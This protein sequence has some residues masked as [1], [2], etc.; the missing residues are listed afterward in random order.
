MRARAI[1]LALLMLFGFAIAPGVTVVPVFADGPPEGMVGVPSDSIESDL[2]EQTPMGQVAQDLQTH[3]IYTS[4]HADTL[5]LL[6]T[7]P[8]QAKQFTDGSVFGAGPIAIVFSDLEHSE[9]REVAIPVV[10]VED[11][12]GYQPDAARGTYEDGSRWIESIEYDGSYAVFSIP[13]FSNQTVTFEGEV[14]ISALA[15]DGDT[16]TYEMLEP[17]AVDDVVLEVTGLDSTSSESASWSDLRDGDTVPIEIGG[18]VPVDLS[19]TLTGHGGLNETD[20]PSTL[21]DERGLWR[22]AASETYL[23]HGHPGSI[24]IYDYNFSEVTELSA[25]PWEHLEFSPDGKYLL[26]LNDDEY[27]IYETDGW[28]VVHSDSSDG[29]N[30]DFSYG[31]SD[32]QSATWHPEGE[33][34]GIADIGLGSLFVFEYEGSGSFTHYDT[35]N[36]G[37]YYRSIK[38][39]PDGEVIAAGGSDHI[40]FKDWKNGWSTIGSHSTYGE[41]LE[42]IAFHP[43]GEMAVGVTSH[44]AGHA[45]IYLEEFD[46][47]EVQTLPGTDEHLF[48][49]DWHP[50]GEYI[51][52]VSRSSGSRV[53]VWE[54][55]GWEEIDVSP[56]S[57]SEGT[58]TN[59][60]ISWTPDGSY[61]VGG[62]RDDGLIAWEAGGLGTV[63][64][65][66]K[67]GGQTVE[68][69]GILDEGETHSGTIEQIVPSA[70]S[71]EISLDEGVVDVALEWVETTE[72][73]DPS[74]NIT[75]D[76]SQTIDWAG[77]LP[78]GETLDWS[79]AVDPEILD[80]D[81][82]VELKI[83]AS[84][85]IS[86]PP[87]KLELEFSHTAAED[88]TV[89]YEAEVFSERY[90]ISH[91]FDAERDDATITIPWASD[92]VVQLRDLSLEIDGAEVSDPSYEFD[93][94]DLVVHLETV[95]AGTN[96]TVEAIGSKVYVTNGSIKVL[97]ATDTA[98][99]LDSR[100]EFLDPGPDFSLSLGE[101][102]R[103]IVVDDVNYPD[104]TPYHQIGTDGQTVYFPEAVDGG[105]VTIQDTEVYLKTQSGHGTVEWVD[106]SDPRFRVIELDDRLEVEY[107]G[108]V[109]GDRYVLYDVEENSVVDSGIASSPVS[110]LT[111]S[112]GEFRIF[113]QDAG[114]S[115]ASGGVVVGPSED[116]GSGILGTLGFLGIMAL[117]MVGS[118]LVG[119]RFE[120]PTAG[121]ALPVALLGG[122][123]LELVTARDIT[124]TV[125]DGILGLFAGVN[126]A[127]GAVV[128]PVGLIG[129]LYLVDRR[130]RFTVPRWFIFTTGG[131]ALLVFLEGTVTGGLAAA[132][133]TAIAEIALGIGLLVVIWLVHSRTPLEIP[134]WILILAA[135]AVSLFIAES[136]FPGA[137]SEGLAE[138]SPAIWIVGLLA[139]GF[140][141]WRRV[142]PRPIIIG[143]EER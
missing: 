11:I 91:T 101:H 58:M 50:S 88:R 82:T 95:E 14:S 83:T 78:D 142:Q 60:D 125:L 35:H 37:E 93:G 98:L 141:I 29:V 15:E 27:S 69:E 19:V 52:A 3:G 8:G 111:S 6:V 122:I 43:D 68:Y 21:V 54:T 67:I 42:D 45:I 49:V 38:F 7:N 80:T 126:A 47:A 117:L 39:S 130:T 1:F 123:G 32:L 113:Q 73:I 89:A 30:W 17:E 102:D 127:V 74:V 18:S 104:A 16:F 90:S 55:T 36:T 5:E 99:S 96:V 75:G 40:A 140:I 66:V 105:R 79:D 81:G 138:V 109:S 24:Y 64:P 53:H 2:P 110:F 87:G 86:G 48:G 25:E 133:D 85:G 108:A 57:F 120:V 112:P 116:G 103:A 4:A 59:M 72:T 10:V 76:G 94:A 106:A 134:E 31:E 34:F 143:G 139:I 137:L 63:S 118:V 77:T 44:N 100:I 124:A 119:R 13:H 22:V 46:Y 84:D 71:T 129:L 132:F 41:S 33:Y 28:N 92:R 61:L 97:E 62:T 128:V 70:L 115:P 20:M 135:G 12:F 107:H 136:I 26:S 131:I 23:A 56:I 65:V 9:G 121:I 114:G 51:T